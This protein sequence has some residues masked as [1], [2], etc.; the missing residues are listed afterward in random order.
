VRRWAVA[1]V[2]LGALATGLTAPVWH[3]DR[4]P[5]RPAVTYLPLTGVDAVALSAAPDPATVA[6]EDL[7]GGVE[8]AAF[9][10][11]PVD[12]HDGH[13]HTPA[14]PLEV[15]V[16]TPEQEVGPFD[17]VGVVADA[18]LDP[19]TRILVRVRTDSAWSPWQHLPVSGHLPDPGTAESAGVRAA[20]E[21][22]LA[23]GADAVQVRIDTPDGTVPEGTQLA[24]VDSP[25]TA[26][27]AD[28]S[29]VPVS[30]VSAAAV[31][32]RIITR[33]QWGADESLVRGTPSFSDTIK[34]GF[35]HH[36]V[37][38]N[39]YAPEEAA[40]QV[41]AVYSWFVVGVGV[42]DF[43]YNF[44]V[45]RFGRIYE[46]RRGSIE[47]AVVG[48]HTSGFNA[49][50]FAVSF[51]GNAETLNPSRA[52]AKPII[53][54]YAKILAW[55]LSQYHRN[56]QGTA[57]LTSAGPGPGQGTTSMYWPGETVRVPTILGHGDI[58]RT[59][60]PGAF[61]N[62]SLAAIRS[63]VTTRIGA[64]FFSPNVAG[65]EW[66]STVPLI[67]RSRT[68]ADIDYSVRV[69]NACGQAV[70][71]L[72]GSAAA[73]TVMQAEW[74]G[75]NDNGRRVPPGTYR[76]ELTGTSGGVPVTPWTGL[77]TIASTATSPPDPCAPPDSFVI[78]GTGYGHGVGL[79]QW[80]ALAMA[81]EGWGA[82]RILRHYYSGTTVA[83]VPD[84]VD[85]RVG[86][87]SKV[88]I[89]RVRA[90]GDAILK[91]RLGSR[92]VP[93]QA[94]DI[95]HLSVRDGRVWVRI[96][97]GD[98]VRSLG[99]VARAGITWAPATTDGDAVA[100]VVGPSQEFGVGGRY[101]RGS[102][103]IGTSGEV[104]QLAV[105]NV[106]SLHDDY[107]FGI[108]EVTPTWP[109]AALQAQVI[110]SRSYALDA[111][112][113]GTRADCLCHVNDG[114]APYY[115]QTYRA[116]D[117]ED[118]VGGENWMAAVTATTVGEGTG[119][120]VLYD[121]API[122]AFYTA[123]TGGRTLSAESVWGGTSY[124]WAVSVDDSW[125]LRVPENPYRTW[126]VTVD[127]DQMEQ[128]VGVDDLMRLRTGTRWFEGGTIRTFVAVGL[129]GDTAAVSAAQLRSAFGLRSAY[130][131]SVRGLTG[132][133]VAPIERT[134]TLNVTPA[135]P[136]AG[137]TVTL[138]GSVAPQGVGL[139]V[140]RQVRYFG[141]SAW[142]ER[143][144][145]VTD[146]SGAFTF[147]I[148]N[149]TSAGDTY[150][151]RVVAVDGSTVLGTSPVRT[152]TLAARAQ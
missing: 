91:V 120:A 66:G 76:F 63:A 98:A 18:P 138:T 51:L 29:S 54:A 116:A 28:L 27:D 24:M 52:E 114:D 65:R 40:A 10:A 23:S 125:S 102:L 143:A 94:G 2:A 92:V 113:D 11:E 42:N 69:L 13:A 1:A 110:A 46:G 119:R 60:C 112:A 132:V 3:V 36:V 8:V 64:S 43:G 145:A 135:A 124:P 33:A 97:T 25:V 130:I 134:V 74:D 105:V 9:D 5:V 84:D 57:V 93:L 62:D 37:S 26:D 75:R 4:D 59:A 49:E 19:D 103:E 106:V 128:I 146:A 101:R 121:G 47:G 17:L 41:R 16:V 85:L 35:I 111:Y 68:N 83:P 100:E 95:V 139:T 31:Q 73:G 70:R 77:G 123:S 147:S 45:D 82:S 15:A 136:A 144:R 56:P 99:A 142:V 126:T 38:T 14:V 50:S 6:R 87:M 55:K 152:V 71:T 67:L 107:L 141:Q 118:G 133:P 58:G 39:D 129:A 150:S 117:V 127:R 61:L 34:V 12:D 137:D 22:L 32:P 53:D 48:A 44:M 131:T 80:G 108:A 78:T 151:W 81:R 88:P 79:S 122:R 72:S 7:R 90:E 30:T 115:D 86:L 140:V 21:P 149:I 89:V 96:R 104:P 148:P 109:Q 20:S